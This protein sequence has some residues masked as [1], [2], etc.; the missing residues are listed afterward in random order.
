MQY[1]EVV[2]A[3]GRDY[4]TA[5]EVKAAWAE[6]KDFQIASIDHPNSGGYVNKDDAVKGITFN[7]RYKRLTQVVVI[8]G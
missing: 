2:P 3:Y 1:I 4:K 5:K 6:G 8:K 7:V